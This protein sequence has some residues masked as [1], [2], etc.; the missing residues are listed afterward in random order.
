MLTHEEQAKLS[1]I[2][3]PI[4]AEDRGRLH[5]WRPRAV[6]DDHR[7]IERLL[8]ENPA[9]L[10]QPGFNQKAWDEGRQRAFKLVHF[11]GP[12]GGRR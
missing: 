1:T 10:P 6:G 9:Q 11:Y 3:S 5:A 12:S 8:R 7:K 2:E 4:S